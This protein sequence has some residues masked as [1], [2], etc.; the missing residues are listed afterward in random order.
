MNQDP[1]RYA[2]LFRTESR[3]QILAINGALLALEQDGNAAEPLSIIFRAFHTVKGMS[4]SMGY[5]AVAEFTH[6]VESALDRVRRGV[7]RVTPNVMDLLFAAVDALESGLDAAT[8]SAG[9]SAAMSGVLEKLQ[10]I[11]PVH[12]AGGPEATGESVPSATPE[13]GDTDPLVGPGI[14][15]RVRQSANTLLPGVR[16]FLAVERVRALGDVGA[17]WPPIEVLQLATTPQSFA[18]RLSSQSSA[19]DIEAAVRSAGDVEHVEV[20]TAARTRRQPAVADRAEPEVAESVRST[21]K[22][23]RHVRMDL[24]RLDSLMN[25]VGELVITRGRLLQLTAAHGEEALDESMQQAARLIGELQIEIM[26]SRMVPVWQMFDRFPR[27]VRDAARQ[28]GKD[29]ILS[30]EG[31]DIELDR[32]LLDEV[33]EPV[34]HLLRNAVDRDCPPMNSLLSAANGGQAAGGT[35]RAECGARPGRRAYSRQR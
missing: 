29:V 22:M 32:S 34:V 2:E 21:G 16:A 19:T 9:P 26:S 35:T 23:T 13:T 7:H 4:A 28:L 31:K 24:A 3:E 14:I 33:G 10:E 6:E 15:V 18:I 30:M 17:V 27:L 1:G 5:R 11:A 25:L 20:D 12:R 8:E